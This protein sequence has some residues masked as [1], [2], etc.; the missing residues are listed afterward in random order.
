LAQGATMIV[1]GSESGE[2]FQ[3][4]AQGLLGRSL[5]VEGYTQR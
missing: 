3:I 5:K 4:S 1:Y 2:D